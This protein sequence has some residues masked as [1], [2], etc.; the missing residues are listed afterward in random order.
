[1]KAFS[2]T[3]GNKIKIQK[4]KHNQEIRQ[5]CKDPDLA[6]EV[7]SHR[8]RWTGHILREEENSTVKNIF[9]TATGRRR[10]TGRSKGRWWDQVQKVMREMGLDEE[11]AED[12]VRRRRSAAE[13]K[14]TDWST[15][16]Y[17][18]SK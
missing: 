2:L 1:M 18:G 15:N 9:K 7:S 10:P 14:N 12:E 16:G 8:L 13:T 11:N 17:Y 5:L 6:V 3:L 4:V